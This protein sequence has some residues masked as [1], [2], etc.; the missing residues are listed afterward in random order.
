MSASAAVTTGGFIGGLPSSPSLTV[1]T[2]AA[3]GDQ[4][5]RDVAKVHGGFLV[6]DLYTANQPPVLSTSIEKVFL[7]GSTKTW[8]TMPKGSWLTGPIGVE[9]NGDVVAEIGSRPRGNV[10]GQTTISLL[11]LNPNGRPIVDL[12]NQKLTPGVSSLA[13]GQHGGTSQIYL[14]DSN[15]GTITRLDVRIQHGVPRIVKATLIASGYPTS[16]IYPP[17]PPPS[18]APVLYSG[19]AGSSQFGL[20]FDPKMDVLYVASM[21]DNAIYAIPQAGS[22]TAAVDKGTVVVKNDGKL[23][24]PSNLTIAPNGDLLVTNND[25]IAANPNLPSPL[26]EYTPAGAYVNS[27]SL[28]PNFGAV[29][30]LVVK[31]VGNQYWLA[32]VNQTASTLDIREV[33]K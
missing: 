14:S 2:I 18:S 3:N 7:N 32:T 5:P 15:S 4:N 31:P 12:K 10:G 13:V 17:V 27:I 21:A 23:R 30:G 8:Y 11:V 9:S 33:P 19:F 28:D 22:R 1:S 20:A 16:F 6:T 26:Y 29:S 24:L 25:G